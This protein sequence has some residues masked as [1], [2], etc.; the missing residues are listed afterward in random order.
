MRWRREI[1]PLTVGLFLGGA[2]YALCV[3]RN[4]ILKN[5]VN[6]SDWLNIVVTL[7]VAYWIGNIVQKRQNES[8][9]EKD[10]MI[11]TVKTLLDKTKH[12]EEIIVTIGKNTISEESQRNIVRQ[13]SELSISIVRIKEESEDYELF[14][15]ID[16][17][18]K[19]LSVQFK[20]YKKA[21]AGSEWR[22]TA[23]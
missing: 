5:E 18:Y 9:V 10:L 8:R 4:I 1:L 12:L 16:V 15:L 19:E 22:C 23:K 11:H 13:I 6:L 21:M 17:T 14:E 3:E 2:L 20:A 7:V